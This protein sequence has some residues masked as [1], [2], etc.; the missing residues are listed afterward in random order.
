ME[1][2]ITA[3]LDS[4]GF[5][6]GPTRLVPKKMEYFDLSKLTYLSAAIKVRSYSPLAP[7]TYLIP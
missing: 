6:V 5:L 3:E 7:P 4:L 1:A 2:K